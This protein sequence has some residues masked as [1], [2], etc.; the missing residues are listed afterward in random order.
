MNATFSRLALFAAALVAIVG[1][2]RESPASVTPSSAPASVQP[3]ASASAVLNASASD[4]D[5]TP[6]ITAPRPFDRA[7]ISL[8]SL[9]AATNGAG[10]R[11]AAALA[12]L[13]EAVAYCDS[14]K[15]Q[16]GLPLVE[17]HLAQKRIAAAYQQRYA[18]HFCDAET[19]STGEIEERLADLDA[20]NEV[21]QAMALDDLPEAQQSSVGFAAATRLMQSA[22]SPV[23]LTWAGKFLLLRDQDLPQVGS[24]PFP[25]S[26]SDR[27]AR[28][29]AQ[30]LAIDMVTCNVS[31]GCGPE[32]F[33]TVSK[34]ESACRPGTT[35]EQVWMQQYS[36]ETI[37][38]ARD[39][40][41]AI[42]QHMIN[43]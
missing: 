39:L 43:P 20:A 2:Q 21:V 11:R 37:D 6:V 28:R 32:G 10:E 31:G 4:H 9:E 33:Y 23:A 27:A 25:S 29:R 5:S 12:T 35:L 36:P 34:C 16:G 1:C 7:G 19:E 13:R 14:I 26:L 30:L 24:V 3:S 42:Q 38:F 41:A 15:A 40:A 17:P 22:K 18:K 8:S